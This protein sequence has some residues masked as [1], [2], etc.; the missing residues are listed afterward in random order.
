[1]L[2]A[3]SKTLRG[4]RNLP[5]LP[6]SQADASCSSGGV[7][8]AR[9]DRASGH[10]V[11]LQ[12]PVQRAGKG[13]GP[14]QGSSAAPQHQEKSTGAALKQITAAFTLMVHL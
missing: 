13:L 5:E 1:M 4:N 2:N 14:F 11:P 8:P 3:H 7:I 12:S 10:G 6:I 9:L